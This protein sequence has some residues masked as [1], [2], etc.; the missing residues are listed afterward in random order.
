MS[1]SLTPVQILAK[2][3]GASRRW[4]RSNNKEV[5]VDAISNY[6]TTDTSTKVT[7]ST[8]GLLDYVFW[9]GPRTTEEMFL[10][11]G[12]T[13]DS[14][15]KEKERLESTKYHT[16]TTYNWRIARRFAMY[17]KSTGAP[18]RGVTAIVVIR[19]P[20]GSPY[21]DLSADGVEREILLPR[22]MSFDDTSMDEDEFMERART[23]G[24]HDEGFKARATAVSF[25]CVDAVLQPGFGVSIV[26]EIK[27]HESEYKTED[28]GQ[29][30]ESLHEYVSNSIKDQIL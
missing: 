16:S 25:W 23:F 2:N 29:D 17:P 6:T 4:R 18:L 22:F 30:E 12:V 15:E 24:C 11:R 8:T 21:L 28:H 27:V 10:M 5:V 9:K 19:L 3:I 26:D 14:W 7:P 13:S 20:A 1:S